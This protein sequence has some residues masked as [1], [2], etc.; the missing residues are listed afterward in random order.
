MPA[1]SWHLFEWRRH[2]ARYCTDT[3]NCVPFLDSGMTT[4]CL[5][6]EDWYSQSTRRLTNIRRRFSITHIRI[7]FFYGLQYISG[8]V[9]PYYRPTIPYHSLQV[10]NPV[11]GCHYF[12]LAPR[13]P[14]Q[15]RS[16]TALWPVPNYT[17]WWQRQM[18]VNN[19]PSVVTWKW[20]GRDSSRSRAQRLIHYINTSRHTM[21]LGA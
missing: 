1:E 19:L 15:P 11:I 21:W 9:K 7:S 10:I 4:D 5:D 18:C 6:D 16:V 13:L 12:P 14:F 20:N 8:D 3:L 17:A 2:P